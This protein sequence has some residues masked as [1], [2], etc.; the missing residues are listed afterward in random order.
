MMR[1]EPHAASV[2]TVARCRRRPS[3]LTTPPAILVPPISSARKTPASAGRVVGW[4]CD[5]LIIRKAVSIGRQAESD[6]HPVNRT[7]ESP[8]TPRKNHEVAVKHASASAPLGVAHYK[9]NLPQN[10]TPAKACFLCC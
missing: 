8:V 2:G 3:A 10:W 6:L 7:H 1:S 4:C 5:V 9:R